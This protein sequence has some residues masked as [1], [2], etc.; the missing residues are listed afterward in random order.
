MKQAR[1]DARYGWQY[2][3][4]AGEWCGCP[5]PFHT[6][7]QAVDYALKRLRADGDS[8][9]SVIVDARAALEWADQLVTNTYKLE[10]LPP[11]VVK[12]SLTPHPR[13]NSDGSRAKP[14]ACAGRIEGDKNV[15]K[16]SA[17]FAHLDEDQGA[18][19]LIQRVL[20]ENGRRQ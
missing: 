4:H 20:C 9:Y 2:I 14:A 18:V 16:V 1:H 6:H 11:P 5:P 13:G 3:N 15:A 12:D 8:P 7:K 10:R 19:I 17:E